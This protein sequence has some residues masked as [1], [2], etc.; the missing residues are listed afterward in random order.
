MIGTATGIRI[1][2]AREAIPPC[3]DA[4]WIAP[5]LVFTEAELVALPLHDWQE[6]QADLE[7]ITLHHAVETREQSDAKRRIIIRHRRPCITT[8]TT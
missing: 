1:I 7:T 3:L 5:P 6:L 8:L 2:P 4:G